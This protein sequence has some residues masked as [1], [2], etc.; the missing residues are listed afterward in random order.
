ML[1]FEE[2]SLVLR[3]RYAVPLFI[4]GD[5]TRMVQTGVCLLHHASTILLV[6]QE[7]K[8]ELSA[9]DPEPRVISEA[10]AAFQMNNSN[11]ARLGLER[12]DSMSI[13][14]ITMVGTRPIFYVVPVTQQLSTAVAR[15]EFPEHITE[16]RKCEVV[17]D[18]R[19][20]SEGMEKPDYRLEALK[21]YTLFRSLAKSL[22]S[23][24]L[25]D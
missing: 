11:R 7:G 12:K 5:P 3:S 20:S 22:W 24:F 16:V 1:G 13:P 19:R 6:V 10:I 8:T 4:C 17:G 15:G 2:R 18:R 25:V 14:C 23:G 9:K 21:H